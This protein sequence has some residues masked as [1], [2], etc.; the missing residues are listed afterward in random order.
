LIEIPGEFVEGIMCWDTSLR[1]PGHFFGD[2]VDRG[3]P[4]V[5]RNP[6][7]K[8]DVAVPALPPAQKWFSTTAIIMNFV[9][10]PCQL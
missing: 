4:G 7:L 8:K 9:D 3:G 1:V 10:S 2:S 5:P 6:R